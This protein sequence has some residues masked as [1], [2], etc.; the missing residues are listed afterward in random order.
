M[1]TR[2]VRILCVLNAS[3]VAVSVVHGISGSAF[4]IANT[5]YMYILFHE[6]Q[7]YILESLNKQKISNENEQRWNSLRLLIKIKIKRI[8]RDF[9]FF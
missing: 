1:N 2:Y 7:M 9:R 3:P 5:T 4:P 6:N 8:R